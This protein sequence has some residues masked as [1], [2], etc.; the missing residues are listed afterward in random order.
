[1]TIIST[2]TG[3]IGNQMFQYAAARALSLSARMP[4]ALCLYYLNRKGV[5][6]PR[7]Y[8]LGIF[9]IHAKILSSTVSRLHHIG[10]G[11]QLPSWLTPRRYTEAA[12]QFDPLMRAIRHPVRLHGY[13][14]NEKYFADVAPEILRD[15][16][17]QPPLRGRNLDISRQL[18][19]PAAVSV[20]VRRADYVADPAA[21]QIHGVCAPDYYHQAVSYIR[22]RI[23]RPVLFFF[24]DDIAWTRAHLKFPEPSHYID[25]NTGG[26]AWEDMRLMSLCH[27]HIIANSSFSWW[28]AWLNPRSDKTVIAPKYWFADAA[29]RVAS[30]DITPAGWIRI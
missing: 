1:M 28:G 23:A 25:W 10:A 11:L 7:R 16:T 26:S 12:F 2:L 15:F 19:H 20:H 24:S 6:A 22:A 27:H 30:E 4:V 21:A 29:L 9:D 18:Q 17:F 3:G 14:Q 13:W 5:V 8:E